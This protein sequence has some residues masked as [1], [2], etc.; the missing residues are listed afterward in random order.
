MT[1]RDVA[2][3]DVMALPKAHLHLHFTGSMR[4]ATL[5]ELAAKHG[6]RLP[7][8]LTSGNPPQL[9]ATDARGWFR[10][11]RL[12]DIARS[13]VRDAD[14][15]RRRGLAAAEGEPPWGSRGPGGPG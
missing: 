3:R 6:V 7:D 14:D 11:Q 5:I 15:V 2:V 4:P 13:C 10:F 8:A 12:Y 9:Q 1:L